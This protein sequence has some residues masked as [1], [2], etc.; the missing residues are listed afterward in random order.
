MPKQQAAPNDQ[1]FKAL[2]LEVSK[3]KQRWQHNSDSVFVF[4]VFC[5]R[6]VWLVLLVPNKNV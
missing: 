1:P 6:F 5:Y 3:R 2:A 4:V